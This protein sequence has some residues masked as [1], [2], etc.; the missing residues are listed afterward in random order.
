MGRIVAGPP[1][2]AEWLAW[3]DHQADELLPCRVCR[4]ESILL[5]LWTAVDAPEAQLCGS[6]GTTL[7][8][9]R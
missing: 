8:S 4:E 9:A 2:S 5:T 7:W 6:C 1:L 3:L